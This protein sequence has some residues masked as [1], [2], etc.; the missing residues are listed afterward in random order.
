MKAITF[1]KNPATASHRHCW[2][3][4]IFAF[5]LGLWVAPA[6]TARTITLSLEFE[7]L[8][9]STTDPNYQGQTYYTV[10]VLVASDISPVTYDEV[11][12][13]APNPAFGGSETGYG[14]TFY[15]D[16]GSAVS[17]AT[18]GV[19]TLTVNKGDVS[20]KQY[21]F[22]VSAS[23]IDDNSFP[24]VQIITPADSSPAV[25]TNTAFA[26][27]GP[28][29][30]DELNLVDHSLDYSFYVGDSPSPAA[31]SWSSPPTLPLGTNEF[32]VTYKTN[33]DAFVTISTPLDNLSQP[34]TNWVSGSK[35][36]DF[37]QSGFVTSTNP[38]TNPSGLIAHYTFDDAGNLG[39][40]SSGN[41]F[42]L[43]Y[44][45]QPY[46]NGVYQDSDSESGGGA[47]H[48]DG[49]SFFSYNSTPAAVLNTL[50]GD[51][52]L[53][54]WIKTSQDDGNENGP[55]YFGAG[56]VAADI[57]GQYNDIIPA[58]LD[59]GQIGFNTGPNDDTVNSTANINDDTYH[60]IVITR[61]QSTGGKQIYID[62]ALNNS[63][64]AT[65][66]LLNDPK[67]VA[68]GCAI[69][70]SQTDPDNANPQQFFNG[71]LDDIQIYS[72]VISSTEVTFLYN[73][74]GQTVGGT[75]FNAALGTTGLN[76]TTSG[77]TSWFTENTNTYNGLPYAA[78]SGSVINNQSSTISVTVT[79][80]GTLSFAWASQDDCN[81][82][83]YEFDIDGD[84]QNDISCGQDWVQDG[85]Y[86][87]PTG[88]HTLTWTTYAYG[89]TD[90]TEAGFLDQVVFTPTDTSPVSANITLNI[91][92]QIDSENNL[93]FGVFP[94]FNSVAPAATGTTTNTLQ[95]PSGY[96]SS[97]AE[98]DGGGASSAI[99]SSLG[100]VLNECTNGLWSLYINY[101]QPN[102]RQFQ[103]SVSISGLT[104]NL[105]A[106]VTFINPTNGATGFPANGTIRWLGLTNYSTV[107]VS[108]QNLDGSGYM[109][110]T[111]PITA[112]SWSPGLA[113]GTNR[114]DITYATNNFP[115]V[116]FT[117]PVDTA[118]SQTVSNWVAQANLSSAATAIFVVSTGPAQMA[119]LN[120]VNNGTNFQFQFLTQ[121]GFTH[122]IL[123]R[124][125]LATG[126]WQTNSIVTGNGT[127]TNI[128]LPY[129]LFSPARQGFIR[130]ST[131]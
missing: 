104:T 10:N 122:N 124:T 45:G 14:R 3:L 131:Q 102:Q 115:G 119:L 79:G 51:F 103:F 32:E 46:G 110:A 81:N 56:I 87:I 127:V 19:W 50:A 9:Y 31:T 21:T 96:F 52:S 70:A 20:E 75:D 57:P 94:G 37:V 123:Y 74:P 130:V 44:N 86:T 2:R 11:D 97:H 72:R 18:N 128:S 33:A 8:Q 6:A 83:D 53:S 98:P 88:Q 101:G 121:S 62:G 69:D 100:Q 12:S 95:S 112:T 99:L 71:L 84:Y 80:P 125:N 34:F 59:G 60:H 22:T 109:G 15:G 76:W 92:Q 42:D 90:P 25:S 85:P 26:W 91:F 47:A 113:A 55:A 48:F 78:Q 35:L 66:D 117:V 77:D 29:S 39:A 118:D 7:R 111:L 120:P 49:G 30:W 1:T 67:L 27:T 5:A 64:T 23:G 36:V 106:G 82:F 114:C 28:G 93:Y 126:F 65:T 54:F 73:N 41:G 38:S 61:R 43:D 58:A 89:D 68:I 13:A 16:I 17:A 107:N 129:S 4:I 63:D 40:D 24:T 116:T 105:L 108:K